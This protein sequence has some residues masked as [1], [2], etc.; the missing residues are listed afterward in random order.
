M[1]KP[2]LIV[3]QTLIGVDVGSTHIKA[4]LVVPGS[5]VVYVAHRAT[6]THAV[7]GGGA[8]HR[9]AEL[10]AAVESA[11]AECVAHAEKGHK[12]A[13]IGIASMAEAGCP[14][15][16]RNAPVGDIM[17]WHDPRPDRQAAWLERQIGAPQL[18]ARTGLRPEPKYTLPKLLWL[19]EQKAADFTRLRHW[20]GVAELVALNL[21]GVLAT[22]ASL[23]CRTMAFDITRRVWD[24]SLLGL[25]SL[26][27]EEMPMVLPLGRAVGGLTAA[28]AA[29]LGLP[30]GTPVAIAGHDH[31]AAALGAGVIKP[32]QALDSMGSAEA[33]LLV[34]QEPA[35]ADEVRRGGFSTGCHAVDGL[36]YVAGGLQSSG[37]LIEWFLKT[38]VDGPAGGVA[39]GGGAS[40][41]PKA[42]APRGKSA[43][44]LEADRYTRFIQLLEL[45]GPGPAEPLV[46]PYLRGR[47]APSRDPLAGLE[48]EGVRETHSLVDLAAAVVDGASYHVRWMLDEL[49][50]ITGTDLDRIKLTGGGARNR[51]WVVTKAALG[52]GRLEVVRTH[53]AAALGAALV[54]GA[55]AGIYGSVADALADA[56]P[57]DRIT[58]P[59]SMRARYDAAY[60]DRW[61]P[62]VVRN[63]R[64]GGLT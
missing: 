56:S 37:A 26:E 41:A 31:L 22:N 60:L 51:R 54:A 30:S 19:R 21:T 58:V 23:A 3:A 5:G 45:A 1:P 57:F 24:A 2:K 16:R 44:D 64:Q 6:D 59:A 12:P 49:G 13:G 29:R 9:P 61:L 38:F 39:A 47:T 17:A 43:T 50:R 15:D 36:A 11:V 52:P 46:R 32:G 20:A 48:I 7:R 35:L 14:V 55:A 18:F 62:A 63:L 4:A 28:A 8:Y 25:A 53:E 34:T 10:L 42:R 27:P 33:T 40:A